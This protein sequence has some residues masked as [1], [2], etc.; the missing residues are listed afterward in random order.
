MAKKKVEGNCRVCGQFKKLTEEHYIPRAAGGAIKTKMYS[1]DELLKSFDVDD[2]GEP[3]KLRGKIK[4]SGLSSYTL[5]KECNEQ[6][7]TNYDKDF[8]RLYNGINY[9]IRNQIGLPEGE[10][11]DDY[12]F[13][14]GVT[15]DLHSVKPMNVAKRVLVSFCS[16]EFEGMTDRFP[17]IR[18]AVM[19]KNY[20]PNTENFALFMSLH[21]GN[22]AFYGTIAAL[23]TIDG[24]MVTQAYAG[25]E[26]ELVAFYFTTHDETIKNGIDGMLDI[27]YWLTDLDYDESVNMQLGLSF[28]KSQHVQFPIPQS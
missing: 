9:G 5:C 19:D 3:Y 28:F 25:I 11:E 23:K 21:L 18:K 20:K 15:M 6:S 22:S 17:E 7:G 2:E 16:I 10:K 1:G 24:K 12:Y 14:K 8:A 4:Q 27:T 13:D 26:S